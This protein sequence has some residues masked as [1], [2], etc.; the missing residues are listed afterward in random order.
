MKQNAT[1]AYSLTKGYVRRV[2]GSYATQRWQDPVYPWYYPTYCMDSDSGYGDLDGRGSVSLWFPPQPYLP[3]AD[4]VALKRF[5]AALEQVVSPF[6][7]GVFLGELRETV[8]LLKGRSL[9]LLSVI[10][11][12]HARLKRIATRVKK[13][14]AKAIADAW[15]EYSFGW[16]PFIA[17]VESAKEAL[18]QDRSK[19]VKIRGGGKAVSADVSHSMVYFGHGGFEAT[20]TIVTKNATSVLYKGAVDLSLITAGYSSDMR[21]RFGLTLRQFVPTAWELLP[22]SFIADYFMNIGDIINGVFGEHR[23]LAWSS[24]N[25]RIK[26]IN[27]WTYGPIRFVDGQPGRRAGTIHFSPPYY[28]AEKLWFT[29]S[30]PSTFVPPFVF[31]YPS[32]GSTKWANLAALAILKLHP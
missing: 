29:R 8:Q 24:K 28:E 16:R 32:L 27:S 5:N 6:T 9:D 2:Q 20:R 1:T 14:P 3:T 13:T 12:D 30:I 25:Q 23:A 21:E 11:R 22:Y 26:A 19:T 18:L 10:Q 7:G 4:A 17:D 15:L 31:T